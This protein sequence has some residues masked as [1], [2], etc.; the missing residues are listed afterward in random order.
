MGFFS[1]ED[2]GIMVYFEDYSG[3]VEEA[4][5][6]VKK[7]LANIEMETGEKGKIIEL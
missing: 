4:Y 2:P 5:N 7:I 6:I 1:Y 3:T